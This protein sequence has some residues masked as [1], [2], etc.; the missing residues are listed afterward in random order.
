[1]KRSRLF[2]S[3][4]GLGVILSLSLPALAYSSADRRPRGA[5][6]PCVSQDCRKP[7]DADPCIS[8]DCRKPKRTDDKPCDSP[9]C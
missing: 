3:V 5:D 7:K 9:G 8:S 6:V 4:L 2:P 1:M